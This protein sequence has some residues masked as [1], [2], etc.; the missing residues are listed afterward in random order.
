MP[1]AA[2]PRAETQVSASRPSFT[3]Q[4]KNLKRQWPIQ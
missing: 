2:G 1:E 3:F 4:R